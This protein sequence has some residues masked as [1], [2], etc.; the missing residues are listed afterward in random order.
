[1]VPGTRTAGSGFGA[2]RSGG[3]ATTSVHQ[4]LQHVDESGVCKWVYQPAGASVCRSSFP[5]VYPPMT[6]SCLTVTRTLDHAPKRA[7]SQVTHPLRAIPRSARKN[8]GQCEIGGFGSASGC[9]A[10]KA[11]SD[12]C[13]RISVIERCATSTRN[14]LG[15]GADFQRLRLLFL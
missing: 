9:V 1:M 14:T 3:L 10:F 13:L 15:L 12:L 11:D 8:S 6:N 5:T 4:P 2:A 7:R